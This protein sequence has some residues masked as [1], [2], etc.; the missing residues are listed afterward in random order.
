VSN[1]QSP[2]CCLWPDPVRYI[3]ANI[4]KHVKFDVASTTTTSTSKI[5]NRKLSAY[6]R[7][8][9]VLIARVRLLIHESS[10]FVRML[11][12]DCVVFVRLRYMQNSR[13]HG[14]V[15]YV[16]RKD[17]IFWAARFNI[18]QQLKVL[19]NPFFCRFA[20]QNSPSITNKATVPVVVV[21]TA[22][23]YEAETILSTTS[24]IS[25]VAFPHIVRP[26]VVEISEDWLRMSLKSAFFV[27]FHRCTHR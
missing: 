16:L 1:R 13:L 26:S 27:R 7:S 19:L 2:P 12:V 17:S 14:V 10:L 23:Q 21:R 6:S 11:W 4:V 25:K 18:F 8:G 22:A 15:I 5:I 3:S 9:Y 24:R 20:G